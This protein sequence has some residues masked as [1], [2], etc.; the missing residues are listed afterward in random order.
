MIRLIAAGAASALAFACLSHAQ[1]ERTAEHAYMEGRYLEAWT[2]L[3]APDSIPEEY[4]ESYRSQTR[5]EFLSVM[6]R[7]F[8]AYAVANQDAS[9]LDPDEVQL[10]AEMV[11]GAEILDGVEAIRT[12][13]QG[14]RVVIV[15]E[16]H[17]EPRHR[18]F[19]TELVRGLAAD[20]FTH[21][22][23]ETFTMAEMLERSV[24]AGHPLSDIGYYSHEPYFGDLIRTAMSLDITL[25]EYED[26]GGWC[27]ACT[28][29]ENIRSREIAQAENLKAALEA[30]PHGRFVVFVGYSHLDETGDTDGEGWMAAELTA[31]TGIDP[32]TIDQVAGTGYGELAQNPLTVA[33]NQM[34]PLSAP[35]V[36]QLPDGTWLNHSRHGLVDITLIH[37]SLDVH[38]PESA[39][40]LGMN[41]CRRSVVI[42]SEELPAQRPI[43]LQAFRASESGDR[44]AVGRRVLFEGEVDDITLHLP[45]GEYD[46]DVQQMTGPDI[47]LGRLA[48]ED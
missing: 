43:L 9:P 20:G 26:R 33:V 14:H 15:N 8:D 48:V 37:P 22:A 44:I 17:D 16:A 31:R 45:V 11:S 12:A 34:Q 30:D 21:F 46:L 1:E 40:W 27:A 24:A 32:L 38:E 4:A 19:M 5:G 41:G 7:P 25:V 47:K 35:S 13:A 29:D 6:G 23:A 42:K 2:L 3:R 28:T 10:F 36:L 39:D 18:A